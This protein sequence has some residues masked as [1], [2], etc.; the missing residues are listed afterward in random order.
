MH[1]HSPPPAPPACAA[2]VHPHQAAD[3][4][5]AGFC[6]AA[7]LGALAHRQQRQN[8]TPLD[9]NDCALAKAINEA[10]PVQGKGGCKCWGKPAAD[11]ADGAGPASA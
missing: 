1:L 2:L 10:L 4:G 8:A 3:G 7:K 6:A 5:H 9:P 11:E